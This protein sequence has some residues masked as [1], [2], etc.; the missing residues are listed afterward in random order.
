MDATN[1]IHI[2]ARMNDDF[3]RFQCKDDF[4]TVLS[5]LRTLFHIP[6]QDTFLIKFLDD[7]GDLCT[8]S[9]Q[10]EFEFAVAH[11]ELLKITLFQNPAV[12]QPAIAEAIPC[13][14]AANPQMNALKE[15]LAA[16]TAKLALPNLPP[17]K[18][19]NLNKRKQFLEAKLSQLAE[20]PDA[21]VEMP[22]WK[23]GCG[24]EN[25]LAGINAKLEQPDLTPEKKERL[26]SRK[27][28]LE[29]KLEQR[30]T[31]DHCQFPKQERGCPKKMHCGRAGANLENRLAWINAKLAQPDLPKEKVEKLTQRK[32][33]LEAQ[34]KQQQ[35]TPQEAEAC[36][37]GRCGGFGNNNL[38]NR[39]A[40]IKT[41]LEQPDLPPHKVEKLT[42]RKEMLEAK[43]AQKNGCT[44][45]ATP[46]DADC[47]WRKPRGPGCGARAGCGPRLEAKIAMLEEKLQQPDLPE[48]KREK[49]VARKAWLQEKL[50]A[51]QVV[52][53]EETT[54]HVM[55]HPHPM[56][57]HHGPHPMMPAPMYHHQGHHAAHPRGH[58]DLGPHGH[59][60][61]HRQAPTHC[62]RGGFC[63]K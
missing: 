55:P 2:K 3:R 15:R 46:A 8:I 50:Q 49:F 18:V 60:G 27:Q 17:H 38:E 62:H 31:G 7:E 58:R 63:R 34:L 53:D 45:A 20:N 33:F 35:A 42:H 32:Q 5:T 40:W 30:K 37:R 1:M 59:P 52:G 4:A 48:H 6:E 21:E 16:V 11:S 12:P 61:P 41:K 39:L 51:K 44:S 24:L 26:L 13:R 10:I 19:Q 14:F 23:Q 54:E 25:R 43:L 28:M 56:M 47:Q 22:A 29:A 57:P 36:P 9:T